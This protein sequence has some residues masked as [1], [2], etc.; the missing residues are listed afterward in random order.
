MGDPRPINREIDHPII[1]KLNYSEDDEAWFSD[2]NQ[3]DAGFRLLIDGDW[4]SDAESVSPAPGLIRWAEEIVGD[5]NAFLAE[6][7]AFL[8]SEKTG[9]KKVFSEDID[10]LEIDCVS[11]GPETRPGEG[12]VYFKELTEDRCWRCDYL[13]KKPRLLG[14]DR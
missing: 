5:A 12:T 8:E 7:Q 4:D 10:A 6:L 14:F 2:P 3:N 1:G 9:E 11:L 13:N